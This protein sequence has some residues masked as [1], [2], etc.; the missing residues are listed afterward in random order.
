MQI[1]N[2]P[3]GQIQKILNS[4]NLIGQNN[5]GLEVSELTSDTPSLQLT[6]SLGLLRV[7]QMV[8]SPLRI[9]GCTIV[10]YNVSQ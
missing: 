5:P 4:S 8:A 6:F 9:Y 1:W 3:I 2:N 10:K 7:Q